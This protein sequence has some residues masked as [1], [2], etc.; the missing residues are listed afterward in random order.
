MGKTETVL[1]LLLAFLI[2]AFCPPVISLAIQNLKIEAPYLELP[3][4]VT[5]IFTCGL[6][7]WTW[8]LDSYVSPGLGSL[9]L[10]QPYATP[11]ARD[12]I[13]RRG[14][15][16]EPGKRNSSTAELGTKC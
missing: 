5:K 12:S 14:A 9:L 11:K 1:Y 2:W 8:S 6:E 15:M 10:H 3:M 13:A 4:R 16:S 7:P